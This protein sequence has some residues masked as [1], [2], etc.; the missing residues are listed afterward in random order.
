M[1]KLRARSISYEILSCEVEGCFGR[2]SLPLE[3]CR[4]AGVGTSQ[5]V[6]TSVQ[7]LPMHEQILAEQKAR[8]RMRLEREK[9]R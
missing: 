6:T 8:L 3:L 1:V 5:E 2:S 7:V 9:G 4:A